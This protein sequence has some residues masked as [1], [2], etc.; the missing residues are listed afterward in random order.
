MDG[1]ITLVTPP[2]I[3]ENNNLGV[4]FVNLDYENQDLVS[5]W[6]ANNDIPHDINLYIYDN[7]HK[8]SKWLLYALNCCNFAFINLDNIDNLTFALSSYVLSISNSSIY[9]KVSD[10]ELVDTYKLINFNRIEN[11][12]D[13][14]EILVSD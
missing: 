8:D 13:F 2:D 6:L 1:K 10:P 5:K 12:K 9:Y 7:Q 14:L 3:F 4:L 11:I